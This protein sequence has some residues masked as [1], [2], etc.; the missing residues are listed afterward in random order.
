MFR[1]KCVSIFVYLVLRPSW[2]DNWI[3]CKD[4]VHWAEIEFGVQTLDLKWQAVMVMKMKMIGI[5]DQNSP[6]IRN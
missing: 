1:S 5:I 6:L 4:W 2:Y 3:W